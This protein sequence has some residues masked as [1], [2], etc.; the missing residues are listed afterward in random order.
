MSITADEWRTL[1]MSEETQTTETERMQVFMENLLVEDS[2][3]EYLEQSVTLEEEDEPIT[4]AAIIAGIVA[5]ATWIME[6]EQFF[7]NVAS[8][9][10]R[11]F[12]Q[13]TNIKRW[14]NDTDEEVEV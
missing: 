2:P 4:I 6:H 3:D 11:T 9:Y 8:W 10:A 7:R 14:Q 12:C 13:I 5:V 1:A